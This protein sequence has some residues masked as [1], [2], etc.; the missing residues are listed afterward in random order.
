[1]AS[2]RLAQDTPEPRFFFSRDVR[3]LFCRLWGFSWNR[4]TPRVVSGTGGPP[5]LGSAE[6]GTV[7]I[8]GTQALEPLEKGVVSGC[9]GKR[10]FLKQTWG[11]LK[12]CQR[13]LL[14]AGPSKENK[15]FF[16]HKV[17]F[18]YIHTSVYFPVC[19]KSHCSGFAEL[20]HK[21]V[22]SSRGSLCR[23][24][25]VPYYQHQEQCFPTCVS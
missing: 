12:K 20:Q 19:E 2:G 11:E 8:P 21:P 13:A 5:W 25:K 15:Y 16:L 18:Y 9:L 10:F 24:R 1:M 4:P 14:L 7:T 17:I 22:K 23:D 6:V 3:I